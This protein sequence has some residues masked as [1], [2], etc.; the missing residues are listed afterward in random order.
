VQQQLNL[1]LRMFS[2]T[3]QILGLSKF[4]VCKLRWPITL[5]APTCLAPVTMPGR[6][7]GEKNWWTLVHKPKSYRHYRWD[8][9]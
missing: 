9:A 6:T 1:G 2:N 5:C 4:C 7:L 8:W 3:R